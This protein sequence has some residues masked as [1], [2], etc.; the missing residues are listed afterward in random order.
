MPPNGGV[1]VATAADT[2]L[3]GVV[4]GGNGAGG[5]A[6]SDDPAAAAAAGMSSGGAGGE[7]DRRGGDDAA[8][9]AHLQKHLDTAQ[10]ATLAE[11]IALRRKIHAEHMSAHV[12]VDPDEHPEILDST[13][14]RF[15]ESRQ[16]LLQKHR[17]GGSGLWT[18]MLLSGVV[19]LPIVAFVVYQK[20]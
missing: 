6:A 12:E 16:R 5:V 7:E 19:G 20:L 10:D 9:V 3:P 15:L 8:M 14:Q 17:G 4:V 11:R 1:A 2:P 13:R 18:G